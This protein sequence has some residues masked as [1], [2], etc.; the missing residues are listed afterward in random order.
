[1]DNSIDKNET[2]NTDSNGTIQIV[3]CITFKEQ[4]RNEFIP[5]VEAMY[6]KEV[7]HLKN[8]IDIEAPAD[9][10]RLSQKTQFHLID[11]IKEYK[12]YYDKL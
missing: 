9:Y 5:R 7:T 4:L 1:M 3:S 11:K 2:P 6:E 12:E 10:I 8:L